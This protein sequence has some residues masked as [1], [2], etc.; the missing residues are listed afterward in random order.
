LI[1]EFRGILLSIHHQSYK[2]DQNIDTF[3]IEGSI[4]VNFQTMEYKNEQGKVMRLY[5]V[6]SEAQSYDTS[7]HIYARK[8]PYN[9]HKGQGEE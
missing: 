4:E 1:D 9:S 5:M 2:N 3:T 6:G 8:R 7:D